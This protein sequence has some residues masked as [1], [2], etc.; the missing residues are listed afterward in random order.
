M[1]AHHDDKARAQTKHA[2]MMP[3]GVSTAVRMDTAAGRAAR[4]RGSVTAY[5]VATAAMVN[6]AGT[7]DP[8]GRAYV[9]AVSTTHISRTTRS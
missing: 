2:T 6:I 4:R 7:G 3:N 9:D 8:H 5:V 1:R